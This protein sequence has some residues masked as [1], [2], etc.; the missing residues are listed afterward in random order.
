M[1]EKIRTRFTQIMRYLS[2][3]SF[4]FFDE[5]LGSDNPLMPPEPGFIGTSDY[6]N[7]SNRSDMEGFL[8]QLVNF[9]LWFLGFAFLL[10]IGY[11]GAMYLIAGDNEEKAQ[12][13]RKIIVA[14]IIGLIVIFMSYAIVWG[15]IFNFY[16]LGATGTNFAF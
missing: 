13:G 9:G 11:G 15:L 5:F 16:Y 1:L 2:G 10:I 14:G 8:I 12:K 4:G 3:A 7:I 6:M